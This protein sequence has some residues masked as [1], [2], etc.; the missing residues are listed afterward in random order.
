[1]LIFVSKNG[2]KWINKYIIHW[3]FWQYL[4]K[5][6]DNDGCEIRDFGLMWAAQPMRI[7]MFPS[8]VIGKK[9]FTIRGV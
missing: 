1:M 7:P 2:T 3:Q 6:F 8:N 9:Q 4:L 5:D